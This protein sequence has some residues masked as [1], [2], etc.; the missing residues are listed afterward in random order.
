[1][2]VEYIKKRTVGC[3]GV[4]K[5]ATQ[6]FLGERH[7]LACVIMNKRQIVHTLVVRYFC[8]ISAVDITI[9]SIITSRDLGSFSVFYG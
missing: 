3:R 9:S 2:Y 1:M 6:L 8:C 4:A 5:G 7:P